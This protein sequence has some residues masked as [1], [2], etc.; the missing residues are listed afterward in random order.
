[1]D[2]QLVGELPDIT[3]SSN[4]DEIMVITDAEH[5]QLRKEKISNF[6]NDFISLNEDN[7]LIKGQDEKLFVVNTTNADNITNGTLSTDRLPSTGVLAKTYPYPT[8][9]EVNEKGQIISVEE[10]E[11]GG[12][13]ANT[14]LSN[15]TDAGKQVIREY[16]GLE[17]GTLFP[18]FATS[19]Y[20]PE[21]AVPT[22]G[23]EY[24]NLQ[25]SDVWNNYLTASTPL[26]ITKN[27]TQYQAEITANGNCAAFGV[28]HIIT[29]DKSSSTITGVEVKTS[30]W[31]TKVSD[32]GSYL[33]SYDGSNWML[34][35]ETVTLS[36][37]GIVLTGDPTSGDTVTV[38]Y[39]YGTNFK[40]P[41]IK[42]TLF[43]GI[44]LNAEAPVVPTSDTAQPTLKTPVNAPDGLTVYNGSG[45]PYGQLHGPVGNGAGE[46]VVYWADP[47]LQAD[48]SKSISINNPTIRWFVQL[49]TGSINESQMDWSQW[50]ASL[51]GKANTD[52]NNLTQTGKANIVALGM[53]DYEAGVEGVIAAWTTVEHDCFVV[54]GATLR[55]KTISVDAGMEHLSLKNSSGQ[56]IPSCS[57][58]DTGWI[59][60]YQ[61]IYSDGYVTVQAFVPKGY[62]YFYYTGYAEDQGIM[63][64]PLKGAI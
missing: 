46:W 11:P 19:A 52:A 63:V 24:S 47:K 28:E 26:L 60:V 8:N 20:T 2:K 53:P 5:N 6:I 13:N 50:A 30:D 15:I 7:G 61:S 55:G 16:G 51:T 14:D 42:D 10:G 54:A 25:F 45:H 58:Y 36:D 59:S 35:K 27:Y 21:G 38:D 31:E 39:T 3:Q 62:S 18:G 57:V 43:L 34:N 12:N 23:T 9:L 48:L 37:Y 56:L 22:D 33:F 1:M 4:D 49:S 41:T 17:I 44:N 29:S 40:V 64:Y 32:I